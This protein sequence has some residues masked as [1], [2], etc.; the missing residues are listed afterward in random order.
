VGQLLD[1]MLK[2]HAPADNKPKKPLDWFEKP[3]RR[4]VNW[5]TA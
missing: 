5:K 1:K 4:S 3:E 2:G